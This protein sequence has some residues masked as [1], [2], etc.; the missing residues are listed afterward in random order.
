MIEKPTS[1]L[2]GLPPATYGIASVV[3][4]CV[5]GWFVIRRSGGRVRGSY[6][7]SI[8]MIFNLLAVLAVLFS[9]FVRALVNGANAA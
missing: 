2:F 7:L 4:A 1:N 6:R 5:V 3:A 9:L 8:G